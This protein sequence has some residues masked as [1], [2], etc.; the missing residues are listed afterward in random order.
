MHAYG[1][2]APV[3]LLGVRPTNSRSDHA[4]AVRTR[5]WSRGALRALFTAWLAIASSY[6]SEAH[7]GA[8]DD[9]TVRS[10]GDES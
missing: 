7:V 9:G 6:R 5:P 2:D 3:D 1:G 10:E 8:A 4:A